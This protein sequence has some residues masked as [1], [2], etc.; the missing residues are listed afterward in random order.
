MAIGWRKRQDFEE[1]EISEERTQ[2]K[3][4]GLISQ[5]KTWTWKKCPVR[6]VGMLYGLGTL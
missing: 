6:E 3:D 2:S 5:S 1:E 4:R